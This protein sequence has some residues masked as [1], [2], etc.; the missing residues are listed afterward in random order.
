MKKKKT[1]AKHKIAFVERRVNK[2]SDV[3]RKISER[4]G[5]Q[6]ASHFY[7]SGSVCSFNVLTPFFYTRRFLFKVTV[8]RS[9]SSSA[10]F[11]PFLVLNPRDL[12]YR[13]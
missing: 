5:D 2:L 9:Y 4:S 12:Y 10:V 6:L 11:R 8:T 1:Y 3:G 7:F 13:G